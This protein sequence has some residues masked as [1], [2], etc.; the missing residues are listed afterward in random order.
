MMLLE[1]DSSVKVM[2]GNKMVEGIIDSGSKYTLVSKEVLEPV[3]KTEVQLVDAN[4]NQVALEGESEMSLREGTI[5][6]IIHKDLNKNMIVG[7]DVI[8]KCP[9]WK[10]LKK[11]V[12]L[13]MNNPEVVKEEVWSITE[14]EIKE[15]VSTVEEKRRDECYDL[16]KSFQTMFSNEEFPTNLVTDVQHRIVTTGPPVKSNPYPTSET[17]KRVIEEWIKKL[18]KVNSISKS[19]SP[20]ASPI[21]FVKKSD[22]SLRL[23]VDY[24]R[25]N[26]VTEKDSYPLPRDDDLF[27]KLQGCSYFTSL[28]FI[29][30]YWQ[31]A[32][33]PEDRP[34][35][36]FTCHLG[37]YQWHV[38]PFGLSNA[39]STFQRFINSLIEEEHLEDISMAKL[40]DILVFSKGTFKEHKEAV[41]RVLKVLQKRNCKLKFKKCSFFQKSLTH[42]GM[43]ISEKGLTP[44]DAHIKALLNIKSPTSL[45]EI[46]SVLGMLNFY[47]RF[48]ANYSM[49]MEP[50]TSLLKK[51][52]KEFWNPTAETALR[53]LLK[54]LT[55][56]P[57]LIF[58]DFSKSFVLQ[59]DASKKG[60]GA[61]IFQDLGKGRQPVAFFSRTL[62]AAEK[63]YP[64]A[65]LEALAIVFG[66]RKGFQ[67][68]HGQ[69]FIIETDH[70]AL[71]YI[72]KWKNKNSMIARWWLELQEVASKAKI[73]YIKGSENVTADVLSRLFSLEEV[74]LNSIAKSQKLDS[75]CIQIVSALNQSGG[76]PEIVKKYQKQFELRNDIL[77]KSDALVIP[78]D[79]KFE[80][81]KKFHNSSE[82][83]HLGFSKSYQKFNE[84]YF[85]PNSL[86]DLRL[87]IN[88]CA[89]CQKHKISRKKIPTE[90]GTLPRV[91]PW[92]RIHIDLVGPLIT[93][94]NGNKYILTVV[95]SCSSFVQALPISA[96]NVKETVSAL[97]NEIFLKFGT[98]Y[99]ITSDRGSN[100]IAKEFKEFCR[101]REIQL[102]HTTAFNPRANGKVERMNATLVD[103]I[104]PFVNLSGTNWDETLP[105]AV[106]AY[107]AA[108]TAIG[109][110]PYY[111]LFGRNPITPSDV[112]LKRNVKNIQLKEF[113]L[114]RASKLKIPIE[115]GTVLDKSWFDVGDLVLR[116]N[117]YRSREDKTSKFVSKWLGPFEVV[118]VKNPLAPKLKNLETNE[119]DTVSVKYLKKY[120]L[121]PARVGEDKKLEEGEESKE[122]DLPYE[123]FEPGDQSQPETHRRSQRV[124][125]PRP[126]SN[127]FLNSEY[128]LIRELII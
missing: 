75:L 82:G 24:R 52:V 87:W 118:S 36:A 61:V 114:D 8:Q 70:K 120:Y 46:R 102:V 31:I 37:T 45:K 14:M 119:L 90:I 40:D 1:C 109:L 68:L 33:A 103:L 121:D 98:P 86:K 25:L 2:V 122:N 35:T 17:Q 72:Q 67:Y 13:L 49:K 88:H 115:H 104:T 126:R 85:W 69:E 11:E 57:C 47:R 19:C 27:A 97:E 29:G 106:F 54:E 53:S 55:Q 94:T 5:P 113:L 16:I 73:T 101:K 92:V 63:N 128:L 10:T 89:V 71:A 78:L 66:V 80:V 51:G 64:T 125:K 81:L 74:T 7:M 32:V 56:K 59:T 111:L 30:G 34:K 83:S 84:L 21:I 43:C 100:F 23:C 105:S 77:Y 96:P 18:M 42:L 28:D 123:P 44:D 41:V 117:Q 6:V 15:K 95:D 93:T 39:P 60:L 107:N 124:V 62:T 4:G 79:L 110:S 38:M 12:E 26:E 99:Q 58:P 22:G 112:L 20:W 48:I 108:P 76:F 3:K 9:S 50:I 116:K 65:G 127:S 91:A